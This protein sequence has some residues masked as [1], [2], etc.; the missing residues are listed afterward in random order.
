[1]S[2]INKIMTKRYTYFGV[3][4]IAVDRTDLLIPKRR[5]A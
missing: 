2:V 3:T 5:I 1:M 4:T